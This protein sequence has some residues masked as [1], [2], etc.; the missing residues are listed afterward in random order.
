MLALQKSKDP[1]LTGIYKKLMKPYKETFVTD[2][3]EGLMNVCHLHNY[4]YAVTM[5]SFI[6]EF[7]SSIQ[8]N[9][10]GLPGAYFPYSSSII[11]IKKFPFRMLFYHQ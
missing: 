10:V 5:Y 6:H 7:S 9:I 8:C 11:T 2:E 1:V 4:A 3:T